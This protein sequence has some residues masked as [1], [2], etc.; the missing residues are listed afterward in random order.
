MFRGSSSVIPAFH[1]L[2]L[3]RAFPLPR[4]ACYRSPGWPITV[5]KAAASE[6]RPAQ[7]NVALASIRVNSRPCHSLQNGGLPR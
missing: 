7:G 1:L 6:D 2:S 4:I 3:P 5:A